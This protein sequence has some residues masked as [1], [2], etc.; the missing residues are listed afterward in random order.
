MGFRAWING[1]RWAVWSEKT[2]VEISDGQG[3]QKTID[4]HR[5]THLMF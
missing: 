1:L 5:E 4:V 3:N 2:I